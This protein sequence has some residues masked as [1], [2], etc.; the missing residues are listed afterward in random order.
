ML[1]IYYLFY[2]KQEKSPPQNRPISRLAVLKSGSTPSSDNY[3]N[4]I[5]QDKAI[6]MQNYSCLKSPQIVISIYQ[7]GYRQM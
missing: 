2:R 4:D 7:Q 1:K 6:N 3:R 5:T